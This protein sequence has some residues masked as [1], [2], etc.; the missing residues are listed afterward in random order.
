MNKK[1]HTFDLWK[2]IFSYGFL[3][4]FGMGLSVIYVMVLAKIMSADSLGIYYL[5][6]TVLSFLMVLSRLGFDHLVVKKVSV[7]AN[8]NNLAAI[9]YFLSFVSKKI[10]YLSVLLTLI[11]VLLS[12]HI[13]Y[14]FLDGID[15]DFGLIIMSC[16]LYFYNMV[17]IY[18]E[19]LKANGNLSLSVLLPNILFPCLNILS[20]SILFPLYG[21]AGVFYSVSL[22]VII[23]YLASLILVKKELNKY[24]VTSESKKPDYKLAIPY[25]FYYIS[26]SN[27]IFASVDTLALGIF[28]NNAE[29]GVYSVIL[30]LVLPFSVLLI[31]VNNVFSP[32]F[33]IWYADKRIDKCINAYKQLVMYSSLFSVLYF[34][35]IVMFGSEM[36]L[37]FGNDFLIGKL[38]LIVIAFGYAV[39]LVTGPS[40]AVLMMCGHEKVYRNIVVW[41]GG[42]GVILSLILTCFFGLI[43]AAVSTSISL[44]IKNIVSF[45]FAGRCLGVK[46][47]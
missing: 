36:L 17:F 46:F 14:L 29:V 25:N 47:L 7:L 10:L 32:K 27:Y 39:L 5:T 8:D 40:A 37:F 30:R 16:I 44:V 26:L 2:Q 41:V 35:M 3:R 6:I 42:F 23:V 34:G 18:S 31:I 24:P 22:S 13:S 1:K 11:T 9:R 15:N 12:E 28:S 19:T 43:G 38:P 20:V 4:V 45:V 21:V 33:S